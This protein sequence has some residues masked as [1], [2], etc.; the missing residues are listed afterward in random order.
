MYS[1]FYVKNIFTKFPK[2]ELLTQQNQIIGSTNYTIAKNGKAFINNIYVEP[3]YRKN[4]D[5]SRLLKYTEHIL[6]YYHHTEK[7]AVLVHEPFQDEVTSFFKKNDYVISCDNYK[8]YDDGVTLFEL[9]P[10][11]KYL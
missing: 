4:G 6:R 7:I 5:G 9:I 11:H 3:E 10:M 1:R 2:I 8:I